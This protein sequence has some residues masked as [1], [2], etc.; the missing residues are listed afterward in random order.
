MGKGFA[1]P[2]RHGAMLKCETCGARSGYYL[3][4]DNLINSWNRADIK[5]AGQTAH[6]SQSD[7]ITLHDKIYGEVIKIVGDQ[8]TSSL[9]ANKLVAVLA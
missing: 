8:P 7:A 2:A 4:E 9:I 1:G 5:E 3:K 6:N